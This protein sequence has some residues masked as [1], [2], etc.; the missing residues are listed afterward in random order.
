MEKLLKITRKYMEYFFLFFAENQ[1][2]KCDLKQALSPKSPA[3]WHLWGVIGK[4]P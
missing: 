4:L 2:V 1:C 3:S